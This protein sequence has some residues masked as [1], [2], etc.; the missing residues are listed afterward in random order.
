MQHA[1]RVNISFTPQKKTEVTQS[2]IVIKPVARICVAYMYS[3]D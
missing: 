1:R 2:F 3:C